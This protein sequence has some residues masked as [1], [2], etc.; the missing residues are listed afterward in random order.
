[1][2][3]TVDHVLTLEQTA[4]F[5]AARIPS[6]KLVQPSSTLFQQQQ[7]SSMDT[8]LACQLVTLLD[9]TALIFLEN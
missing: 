1:M 7:P 5:Y 8:D 3:K 4:A 6:V 2:T 9:D